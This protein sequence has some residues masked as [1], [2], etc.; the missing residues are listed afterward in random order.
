MTEMFYYKDGNW[1]RS[2]CMCIIVYIIEM[3]LLNMK[4]I[5]CKN[6]IMFYLS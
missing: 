5:N 6:Y 4:H 2:T 3:Q 1:F